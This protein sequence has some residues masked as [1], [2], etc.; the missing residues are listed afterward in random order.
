MQI[1]GGESVETYQMPFFHSSLVRTIA[2]I[3]SSPVP[4]DEDVARALLLSPTTSASMP[5]ST[6]PKSIACTAR[7]SLWFLVR[8][9]AVRISERMVLR[10]LDRRVDEVVLGRRGK[11]VC[12]SL[13]VRISSVVT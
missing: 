12:K 6:M 1:N 9:F 10:M 13:H 4:V 2:H 7:F 11:R 5:R 8:K 3:A